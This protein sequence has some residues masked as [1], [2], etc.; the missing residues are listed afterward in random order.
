MNELDK[1]RA[2]SV[3]RGC[4]IWDVSNNFWRM[5]CAKV[6]G[7]EGVVVMNR[8]YPV[9]TVL[10]R[11]GGIRRNDKVCWH[12]YPICIEKA[13]KHKFLNASGS[14][15]SWNNI[16]R[17]YF[18]SR[19]ACIAHFLQNNKSLEQEIGFDEPTPEGVRERP[20]TDWQKYEVVKHSIGEEPFVYIGGFGNLQPAT[21]LLKFRIVQRD[22]WEFFALR[23]EEIYDQLKD[24]ASIITVF[25]QSQSAL[26]C[27]IFQCGN[28]DEGKWVKMG[29]VMGYA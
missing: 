29:T 27:D 23:L 1:G 13:D 8:Q 20:R 6:L 24:K 9:G 5:A 10:W 17:T 21:L 2:G 26:N 4:D 22:D 15:G 16:G 18:L 12:P 19:E 25:N 7:M 14:G 28:Y 11:M 3:R